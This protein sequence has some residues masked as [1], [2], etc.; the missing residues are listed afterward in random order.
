[1][2]EIKNLYAREVLDSRGNPTVE[3]EVTT[4]SLAFG[5]AIV[6]S[7]ASTGIYEAL[8]LRDGKKERYGGKGVQKAV[9]HVNKE[10]ARKLKG[11]DV[12][13]QQD[14]DRLLLEADGTEH[15]DRMGA[16]ALLGVSLAC[17]HAG[18]DYTGLPL[19]Q[20]LGGIFGSLMP[21]PMMNILNG[22]AH[23]DNTLDFQEFMIIPTGA[24]SFRDAVRM[25]SEVFHSLK[26]IL[27]ERGLSTA[28]GDEGGFAPDLKSNE[29]GLRVI[30]QAIEAAG[31]VPGKDV[32]LAL[33]V[34]ASE[35]FSEGYYVL[36]GEGGTRLD[37][38]E[39]A[40]YY[41]K[42]IQRYPVVSIE[43]GCDQDDWEGWRHM[44]GLL[45]D[46]VQLVGD[47]FFVTNVS[48]LEKGIAEGCANAILIKPNQIGT[49]TETVQAVRM[50][51]RAGYGAIISHRS[52]ESEDTTIADLAVALNAGQIK[53]GSMSRTD[54]LAKY[55]QLMRIEEY[56]GE[57]AA[58]ARPFH[59]L[60][61]CD[62]KKS[63]SKR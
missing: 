63:G 50:A 11:I 26:N 2:P 35:F 19:H 48:R 53:T 39:M 31:Y 29:E 4:E 15:K 36:K 20:Y 51:Q 25:G 32:C 46:K 3:V 54:R 24:E 62:E 16:N 42:L 41:A 57:G 27:K 23:A 7:G 18:A 9:G 60:P 14:I 37:S 12:T 33:D 55:N 43:D 6:P 38:R 49:L 1:M 61:C 34:A 58:L 45:G 44:T 28:V 56:L 59:N 22:G 13:R 21:M 5:R 8:E 30:T 10:L 47:D 52:G 17:A 40:E